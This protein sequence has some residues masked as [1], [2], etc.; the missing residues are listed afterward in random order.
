MNGLIL[1]RVGFFLPTPFDTP[2]QVSTNPQ[3]IVVAFLECQW[4]A[5]HGLK[6]ADGSN[7]GG[8]KLET[9]EIQFTF[10]TVYT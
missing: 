9:F 3:E 6:T 10:Q 7:S 4:L 1:K 5:L 2:G 8:H